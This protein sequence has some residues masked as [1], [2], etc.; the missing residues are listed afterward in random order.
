[1]VAAG[2]VRRARQDDD[3]PAWPH[4]VNPCEIPLLRW[5]TSWE[6][7]RANGKKDADLHPDL[8]RTRQRTPDGRADLGARAQDANL[9]FMD[10]ASPDGTGEELDRLAAEHPRLRVI[11]RAGK[12]G[13]GSAHLD[14]NRHRLR[15]G[16]RPT[17][18]ARLRLHPSP[19]LIPEFLKR[20]DAADAVVGSRYL[21][22]D[23]LPG[24]SMM[25][26]SLTSVGHILTK[27]MLGISQDATGAFRGLQPQH[28]SARPLPAGPVEGLCV[29]LRK[30]A[31]PPAQRLRD[32]RDP[33]Q[34]ARPNVRELEDE[35]PRSAAQRL[36]PAL[37]VHAGSDQSGTI[38][39]GAAVAR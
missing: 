22:R 31:G 11:H 14:G 24:W 36:D 26:K 34:A 1:M 5:P 2:L 32:R 15:P 28:A 23:S 6:T 3:A 37:P 10:D 12:S 20:S 4:R 13:I 29:L 35:P 7:P 25:R 30:H 38:S 21:E 8:Q 19:S 39:A 18:H 16:V 33:D 27:N 17:G 9:V